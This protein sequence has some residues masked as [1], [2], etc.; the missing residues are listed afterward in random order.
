VTQ[1]KSIGIL[2]CGWLGLPL[3]KSLV[4]DGFE[5]KGSTTRDDKLASLKD[6]GIKP[7]IIHLN[8]RLQEQDLIKD[9]LQVDLLVVNIPPSLRTKSESFHVEQMQEVNK[10]LSSSGVKYLIYIS[11]TSVYPDL[12]RVVTEEDVKETA[13]AD[14]KT[15]FLAEDIFRKNSSLKTIIIRCAGLAGYDRNLVKHFAGKKEL[16]GGN[17]PVNLIHRDDVIQILNVVIKGN[18]W[19]DTIN[20]SAPVHPLRKELYPYLAEKYN[21]PLPEYLLADQ[22]P[23]KIISIEKLKSLVNYNFKF[24]DPKEFSF[25]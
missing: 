11:S 24:P 25:Q 1:I 16:K 5:V 10:Y 6:A 22:S 18:Y 21:Y 4:E 13:D 3:G 19:N 23:F 7:Y 12:N 15:L 14:A 2:G 9:F 17:S 20:I 8:P